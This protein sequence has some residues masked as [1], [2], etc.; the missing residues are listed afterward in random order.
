MMTRDDAQ[1]I[2]DAK[3]DDIT[4]HTVAL[5]NR[6]RAEMLRT[7]DDMIT[8]IKE[9]GLANKTIT[10]TQLAGLMGITPCLIAQ[11][12]ARFPAYFETLH[13]YDYRIPYGTTDAQ[14]RRRKWFMLHHHLARHA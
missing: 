11:S 2:E 13:P 9:H 14:R 1:D 5:H 10:S 12:V 4:D 3:Q 6:T 7:R 8:A